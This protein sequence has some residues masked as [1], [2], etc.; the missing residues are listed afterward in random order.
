M[1]T[2]FCLLFGEAEAFPIEISGEKTVGVLKKFIHAENPNSFRGID[3]RTLQLW[4]WNRAEEVNDSELGSQNQLSV[5]KTLNQVF[6]NKTP[7]P[8]FVHIIIKALSTYPV[9]KLYILC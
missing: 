4:E 2:L 3:A 5:R 6:K 1:M 8:E 7:N 9:F